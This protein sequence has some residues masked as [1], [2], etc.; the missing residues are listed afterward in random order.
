[1][2]PVPFE[3][4]LTRIFDE[5]QQHHSILVFLSSSIRLPTNAG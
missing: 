2:R 1:M 4:L 3:E 5:Y